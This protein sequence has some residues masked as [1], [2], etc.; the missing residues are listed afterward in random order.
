MSNSGRSATRGSR[1]NRE[2]IG[3]HNGNREAEANA[4]SSHPGTPPVKKV[5]ATVGIA[6]GVLLAAPVVALFLLFGMFLMAQHKSD[7]AGWSQQARDDI[8][9]DVR[10][11]YETGA[12]YAKQHH[13]GCTITKQLLAGVGK[14]ESNHGRSPQVAAKT[15]TD[16]YRGLMQ[17][18]QGN[19]AKPNSLLQWNPHGWGHDTVA[20][21][22]GTRLTDLPAFF[23]GY[24]NDASLDGYADLYTFAD[25]AAA[26]GL[27]LCGLGISD[28]ER[29]ALFCYNAGCAGT[30]TAPGYIDKVLG[31]RDAYTGQV[32]MDLANAQIIVGANGL[33]CPVAGKVNFSDS[34]G[35]PRSGGRG[36]KGVDMM[37]AA[38][39]PLVAIETGE[40][41]R[42][43]NADI[44]LGGLSLW[45]RGDTTH[46]T[47]YYAHNSRNVVQQGDRVTAGQLVAAVG[48]SG[49]ASASAPHVHF[50]IHP[51]GGAA[52]NPTPLVEA[53]C[54]G[55]P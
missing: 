33:V 52:V 45:V 53:A 12:A 51:G 34:W 46:N 21:E 29:R 26:A 44:G 38:G 50:E 28:D 49:N 5:A 9:E 41:F 32:A 18:A 17:I 11:A 35:A 31:Y 25:N 24:G 37:A 15:E 6:T 23:S 8:P 20:V 47:Y 2:H 39:T 7:D 48:S 3:K 40:V 4:L 55:H 1:P 54:A 19:W 43:T 16:P 27:Q 22:P 13:P 10:A 36:H 42:V 30:A 14:V